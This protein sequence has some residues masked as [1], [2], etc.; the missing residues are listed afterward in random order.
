MPTC[1]DR[2]HDT[3]MPIWAGRCPV[4]GRRSVLVFG[5]GGAAGFASE[6]DAPSVELDV[7]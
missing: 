5:R 6:S 4:L 3:S 7:S 1:L 2:L